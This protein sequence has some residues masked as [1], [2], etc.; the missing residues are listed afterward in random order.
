MWFLKAL[1][2]GAVILLCLAF[3]AGGGCIVGLMGMQ[4]LSARGS[5]VWGIPVALALGIGGAVVGLVAGI[6]LAVQIWKSIGR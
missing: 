1:L 3:G 4:G 6:A 5:D 2:A